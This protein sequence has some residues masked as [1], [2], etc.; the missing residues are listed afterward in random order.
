MGFIFL[1]SFP[2]LFFLLVLDGTSTFQ[3]KIEDV[4]VPTRV[5]APEA[6]EI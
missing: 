5:S 3:A 2:I 6:E 4:D 1:Q